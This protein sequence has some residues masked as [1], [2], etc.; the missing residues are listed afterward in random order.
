MSNVVVP[1]ETDPHQAVLALLPWYT[2]ERL[3]GEELSTVREHLAHC[4][5]CRAELEAERSLQAALADSREDTPVSAASTEAALRRMRS[6][7]KAEAP[8][9][10]KRGWMPWAIG[11]QAAAITALVVVVAQPTLETQAPYKGLSAAPM[12]A[13]ATAHAETLVMFRPDADEASIRKALLA[14]HAAVVG[15]PTET[16]AY[17]LQL[18]GGANALAALRAESVVSLAESLDP[19]PQP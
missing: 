1:I 17:R 4:A 19:A 14:H 11:L 10:H 12:T 9:P 13:A 3:S 18:P 16:G 8:A 6:L 5:A 15:G 2:R 7:M